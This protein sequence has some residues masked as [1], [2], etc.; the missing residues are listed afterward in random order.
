MSEINTD[1]QIDEFEDNN[2]DI[3]ERYNDKIK[4]KC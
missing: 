4:A 3:Y 1:N 2:Q